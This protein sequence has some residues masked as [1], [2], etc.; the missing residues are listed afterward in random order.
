[1]QFVAG[2]LTIKL[3]SRQAESKSNNAIKRSFS[4]IAENFP[5]CKF[6]KGFISLILIAYEI[7]LIKNLLPNNYN[8][9]SK[10]LS[11]VTKLESVDRK[12]MMTM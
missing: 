9:N 7:K 5:T 11:I 3:S 1:M 10:N 2:Y 8:K 6:K 4:K 12:A